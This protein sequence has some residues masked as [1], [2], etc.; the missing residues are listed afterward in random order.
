M[1]IWGVPGTGFATGHFRVRVCLFFNFSKRVLVRKFC[2][3]NYLGFLVQENPS[4]K[5]PSSRSRRRRRSIRK[6]Q[7][8]PFCAGAN[9]Q[10]QTIHETGVPLG[11][12]V[13]D[14]VTTWPGTVWTRE[15]FL[16]WNLFCGRFNVVGLFIISIA[17][18]PRVQIDDEVRVK[19]YVFGT[20]PPPPKKVNYIHFQ[21]D[22]LPM[23]TKR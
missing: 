2:D 14:H 16:K 11:M 15:T 19:S 5:L 13:S 8:R 23:S 12:R 17:T 18:R 4:L 9:Y 3:A 6:S 1:S 7:S 22:L 20:M 10:A 21:C